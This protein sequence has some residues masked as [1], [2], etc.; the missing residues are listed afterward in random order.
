KSTAI[1]L[2]A[3][4]GK[5]MQSTV[6]KQ[7]MLLKEKPVIWYALQAFETS[8][9]IDRVILVV[10]EGEIPFCRQEI[11]EKYGFAKVEA[12]IEGGA[13]R[14]LS[15]WE[16]LCY[17]ETHQPAEEGY[18]FIHDGARPF[19]NERILEDTYAAA[20]EY[21]ACVAGMPVKDT[22]KIADE[23]E[24]SIQTPNRRT[25]WAVQTPQVFEKKLIAEAYGALIAQLEELKKQGIEITDDAMV[26]ETML[27]RRVKLVR[28]SY[29]NMK[30]TT[31][32]DMRLAECLIVE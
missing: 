16:G 14:Y 10:G 3:G 32:E 24:F 5:R 31:P 28:A 9:I 23:E 25:V 8:K 20:K 12:V 7:Y 26:V 22:I 6:A 13:E 18:V 27:H 17:L 29:E 15:V 2:A 21:G 4:A 1:V 11:V 30:L 19:V